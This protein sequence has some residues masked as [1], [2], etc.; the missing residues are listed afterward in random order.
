MLRRILSCLVFLTILG[1]FVYTVLLNPSAEASPQ[2]L[3]V[4]IRTR[5]NEEFKATIVGD[6]MKVTLKNNHKQ[7][8]TAYSILIGE[9]YRIVTDYAYS[10]EEL[11]VVGIAPGKTLEVSYPLPA[12]LI[13]SMPPVILQAVVLDDNNAEGSPAVEHEIKDQ[14]LGEKIQLRRVLRILDKQENFPNDLTALKAEISAAL[15]RPEAETLM[16]VNEADPLYGTILEMSHQLKAGLQV[17]REKMLHRL[18]EIEEG[19]VDWRDR[20]FARLKRKARY[21]LANL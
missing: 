19:P 6:Q 21:V 7:A 10:E 5:G 14:R 2:Q 1:V 4:K 11:E 16:A 13:A 9:S 3:P 15:D 18:S 17:G 8:I 20:D 12:S